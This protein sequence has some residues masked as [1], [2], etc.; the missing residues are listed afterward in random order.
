MFCF[1]G[2][3]FWATGFQLKFHHWSKIT[4]SYGFIF[5]FLQI[6][7]CQLKCLL[8]LIFFGPADLSFFGIWSRPVLLWN[9][10]AGAKVCVTVSVITTVFSQK[11][12]DVIQASLYF[13]CP[14]IISPVNDSTFY[15]IY[16][17]YSRS[18]TYQ[19]T[20]IF[21]FLDWLWAVKTVSSTV[22]SRWQW[23][24]LSWRFILVSGR[25]L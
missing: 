2:G 12:L 5:A 10:T 14:S 22:I 13:N 1:E 19:S 20:V 15:S 11:T 8:T 21:P 16:D 25:C 3:M 18:L 6:L 4:D 24:A 23:P 7:D 17:A 9:R